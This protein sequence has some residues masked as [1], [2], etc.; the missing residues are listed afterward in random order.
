MAGSVRPSECDVF[1]L[2]GV[3]APYQ[4]Q[5]I[6]AILAGLPAIA[7]QRVAEALQLSDKQLASVVGI[8]VTTLYR[9]KK[10]GTF[11]PDES[12]RL[13]RLAS[14]AAQA[15]TVFTS[16]HGANAWF[17]RPNEQLGGETPLEYA[18]TSVGA[19]EVQRVLAR[20]LDGAPA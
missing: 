12:D 14:L 8:S 13:S 6:D 2:L 10:E 4:R 1:R 17:T 11:T 5:A 20:I 16:R 18:K 9:R 7:W 3:R 15:A 19:V